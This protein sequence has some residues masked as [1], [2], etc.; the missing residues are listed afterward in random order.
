MKS[1]GNHG[2][3]VG[4]SYSFL[5]SSLYILGLWESTRVLSECKLRF[6][7]D[8]SNLVSYSPFFNV[9]VYLCAYLLDFP[10]VFMVVF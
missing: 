4:S 7:G 8:K 5:Y 1:S 6:M 10:F 9:L 3:F 2:N